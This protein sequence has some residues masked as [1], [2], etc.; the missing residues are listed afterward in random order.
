[1]VSTYIPLWKIWVRQLGLW[2]SQYLEK[3]C[4]K[5]PTRSSSATK[6]TRTVKQ[7]QVNWSP[8][9]I[10]VKVSSGFLGH[11]PAVPALDLP[12]CA[13]THHSFCTFCMC[14]DTCIKR[15]NG[16]R[17]IWVFIKLGVP[18]NYGFPAEAWRIQHD[19]GVPFKAINFFCWRIHHWVPRFPSYLNLHLPTFTL[20][21]FNMA[22][23]NG[24][25][26]DGLWW[27]TY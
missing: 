23:E 1:M 9:L 4:S 25:H 13:L 2:N 21:L 22:M 27:Y 26:I 18:Q 10:L 20:W 3:K 7:P 14:I 16:V 15:Q 6:I 12:V 5:P 24:P 19:F 8:G 11:V 17:A